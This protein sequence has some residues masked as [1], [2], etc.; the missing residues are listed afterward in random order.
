MCESPQTQVIPGRVNPCSGPMTCT[1]PK[2]R[3]R[4]MEEH[5]RRSNHTLAAVGH[6]KIG[7]TKFLHILLQSYTLRARVGF[8]DE[9]ADRGEVLADD[10]AIWA[11]IR[12]SF[13]SAYRNSTY[14]ILWSTVARVQSVRRTGRPAARLSDSKGQSACDVVRIARTSPRTPVGW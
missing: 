1:I 14:G 6:A 2:I 5:T 10:R 9:S 3:V 7:N 4:E 13:I 8:L 11:E 12:T